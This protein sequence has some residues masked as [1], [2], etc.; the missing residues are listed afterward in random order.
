M[1]YL[2]AEGKTTGKYDLPDSRRENNW[3]VSPTWQQKGIQLEG[4]T[5]LTAE[6]NTTG[7]YDLPDSRSEYNWK[8]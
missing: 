8:V 4:M 7:R 3:K 5:Y 1:T 2:T 6:G